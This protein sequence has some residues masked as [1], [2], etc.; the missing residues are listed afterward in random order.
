MSVAFDIESAYKIVDAHHQ[1]V[2]DE[3]I[4]LLT[5]IQKRLLQTHKNYYTPIINNLQRKIDEQKI[6]NETMSKRAEGIDQEADKLN[7]IF[8]KMVD[9]ISFMKMKEQVSNAKSK[10][11]HAWR[12]IATSRRIYED[13][14]FRIYLQE[15]MKRILFKRWVR[16][17]NKVRFNRKKR[18]LRR[19]NSREMKAQETEATQRITALQ[20]ELIAV[21]QLLAEHERQNGEMQQKLRR[22][23]MRGVVNL[24]LEAV[25][26]FGEVPA[27]DGLVSSIAAQPLKKKKKMELPK[28]SDSD[29][30]NEDFVVE[31]APRISVIH[32]N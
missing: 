1:Q 10:L 15:P 11:L 24:N 26:V 30:D 12:D 25:D 28:D 13:T 27:T 6:A 29:S 19:E 2:D 3:L 17:M 5:A 21:R 7:I 8:E 23:F 22:A 9:H 14:M 31:P 20:S 18:E 4:A 16:R 32:H